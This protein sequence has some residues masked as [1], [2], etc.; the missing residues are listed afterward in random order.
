MAIERKKKSPVRKIIKSAAI[1]TPR[2]LSLPVYDFLQDHDID[3]EM[4]FYQCFDLLLIWIEDGYFL[5]WETLVQFEKGVPIKTK[6]QKIID[7]VI[8]FSIGNNKLLL[9]IGI[10][11]PSEPWY[12]TVRKVAPR[13][14]L[15]PFK[16]YEFNDVVY[17]NGWSRL[18]ECL[19]KHAQ[20]LSL[21]DGVATPFEVIP[22][23]T[24]QRLWLQDCFDA[25]SGLG[26]MEELT[27]E[28]EEQKPWRIEDFIKALKEH[29]DSVTYFKLSIKSLI[30]MVKL[31]LKDEKILVASLL[32]KLKMKSVSEPIYDYL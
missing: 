6:Q 22:E 24:R 15:D 20:D 17:H 12:E 21:P 10:F 4:S 16:T 5:K 14:I 32:E 19:N 18:V 7:E 28:N 2:H 8:N 29:K 9:D 1:N 11:Q 23:N 27:L 25:L 31:P 30:K 13:L 3:R 26:Q